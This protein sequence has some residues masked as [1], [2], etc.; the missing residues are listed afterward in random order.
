MK[1]IRLFKW[2]V[3][4]SSLLFLSISSSKVITKVHETHIN[5]ITPETEKTLL[6]YFTPFFNRLIIVTQTHRHLE[7]QS[8]TC[9]CLDTIK[10]QSL[11]CK[12]QSTINLC[13]WE[14]KRS[15]CIAH[16]HLSLSAVLKPL[17]LTA[18]KTVNRYCI[19]MGNR[20]L[21]LF[22]VL[23][24]H[25]WVVWVCLG[26][27]SFSGSGIWLPG[28][29]GFCLLSV[30]LLSSSFPLS[31]APPD[32]DAASTF[33]SSIHGV[34]TCIV[35]VLSCF[36]L[37]EQGRD[38]WETNQQLQSQWRE[39]VSQTHSPRKE[40]ERE[41]FKESFHHSI[42]NQ[43]LVSVFAP[44]SSL[45]SSIV[46]QISWECDR[47]WIPFHFCPSVS[48]I[49]I[50]DNINN[51]KKPNLFISL[52]ASKETCISLQDDIPV[53]IVWLPI[54]LI[55]HSFLSHKQHQLNN[56]IRADNKSNIPPMLL[57]PRAVW[58]TNTALTFLA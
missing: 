4:Q 30:F 5:K 49:I 9:V 11:D 52:K 57:T 1:R 15:A 50:S 48:L 38:V 18:A 58:R 37:V 21:S 24:Q 42:P 36:Q 46:C 22:R 10:D 43:S 44:S 56:R 47:D 17:P 28:F 39:C 29:A 32:D 40:G 26:C 54:Q 14:R 45:L 3:L 27:D 41:R 51:N 7:I 16:L 23:L 31:S 6:Y 2:W 25:P 19:L 34:C 8:V 13:P 53:R 33:F 55:T 12:L 35:S 20:V